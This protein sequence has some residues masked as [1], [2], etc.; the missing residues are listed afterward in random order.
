MRHHDVTCESHLDP[1]LPVVQ[2]ISS[3]FRQVIL[4][5]FVNAVEAMPGGGRLT[6][7]TQH[8]PDQNRVQFTVSDTGLGINPEI[9]PHI[10]EPFITDKETG[11]GLGLAIVSDI[12]IRHNGEVQAE[13]NPHG[14]ATIRA[15]LPVKKA[16]I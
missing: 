1:E 11:T 2:G 14:G 5:L 8:I 12:V 9:L 6:I 3:Q 4:N 10:F 7:S 16:Q 13:N 15:W